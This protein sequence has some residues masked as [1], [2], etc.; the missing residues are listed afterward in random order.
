MP[1]MDGHTASREI[2]NLSSE[3]RNI[4]II[5]MTAHAMDGDE[6]KSLEAGMNDHITKPIDPDKMFATLQKWIKPVKEQTTPQSPQTHELPAENIQTIPVGDDL[7]EFL[8][9]FDLADGLKRLQGNKK[10]Y[11]KLLLNFAADYNR[12]GK[13][14]AEASDA[15]KYDQA[16]SLVHNLKGLAGNLAATQLEA[17]AVNLEKLVNGIEKKILPAK[18]LT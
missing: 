11:R 7:P 8:D 14:I 18:E 2:R 9:G 5:A 3:I 12:V 1:V 6:Q 13:E 17:A 10:L 15:E 16:E 4:P